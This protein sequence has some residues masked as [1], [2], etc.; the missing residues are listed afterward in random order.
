MVNGG[1]QGSM[2]LNGC[3]WGSTTD[4]GGQLGPA[5]VNMCQR[6]STVS[7]VST[8][9]NRE[10]IGVNGG[11]LSQWGSTGVNGVHWNL[12]GFNGGLRRQHITQGMTSLSSIPLSLY[13]L[14]LSLSLTHSLS[15]F[16]SLTFYFG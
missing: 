15:L 2:W 14:S 9:D 1:Q 10:Q 6:V 13:S 4:N 7:M 5:G 16:L 12:M 11:Q 8:G 3:Q